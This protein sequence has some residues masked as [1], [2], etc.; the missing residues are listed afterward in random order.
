[1]RRFRRRWPSTWRLFACLVS[2]LMLGACSKN[3]SPPSSDEEID[4]AY[5]DAGSGSDADTVEAPTGLKKITSDPEAEKLLKEVAEVYKKCKTYDDVC[6]MESTLR[7]AESPEGSGKSVGTTV[8]TNFSRPDCLRVEVHQRNPFNPTVNVSIYWGAGKSTDEFVGKSGNLFADYTGGGGSAEDWSHL[9]AT[10][11]QYNPVVGLLLPGRVKPRSEE[12]IPVFDKFSV[13]KMA[14]EEKIGGK[15]CHKITAIIDTAA[16]KKRL[17]S[18]LPGFEANDDMRIESGATIWIDKEESVF[19]KISVYAIQQDLGA[20]K[21]PGASSSIEIPGIRT[22]VVYTFKHRMN[23]PQSW[24]DLAFGHPSITT[25]KS[26]DAAA[27]GGKSFKKTKKKRAEA[28]AVGRKTLDATAKFYAECK[29]Y[30]DTGEMILKPVDRR[31]SAIKTLKFKTAYRRSGE[32]RFAHEF[33][34]AQG[35]THRHT[36]WTDGQEF[37][38]WFSETNRKDNYN[39]LAAVIDELTGNYNVPARHIFG[40]ID[41]DTF[42]E[43]EL[44]KLTSPILLGTDKIDGKVCQKIM[45]QESHGFIVYLW[46]ETKTKLIRRIETRDLGSGQPVWVTI[47]LKPVVNKKVSDKSLE[48]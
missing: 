3:S 15:P 27:I 35:D 44:S 28:R 22:D 20:V 7:D 23:E 8:F 18:S 11:C 47:S 26:V 21:L 25:E 17:N 36:C 46:I 12:E 42:G 2:L 38:T 37:K 32:F 13:V 19:R 43:S 29:S 33:K 6:T 4:A 1:M 40:L 5:T 45:G 41:K 39:N 30:S 14:G 48:F 31:D 34:T 10:G 24:S 16:V 9:I